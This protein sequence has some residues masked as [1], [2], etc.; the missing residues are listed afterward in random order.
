LAAGASLQVSRKL[1]VYGELGTLG[2]LGGSARVKSSAQ[3]SI[4][5]RFTL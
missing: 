1:T 3:G 5:I 2:A 4:G